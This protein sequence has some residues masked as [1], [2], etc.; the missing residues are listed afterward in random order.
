MLSEL[1]LGW[2][3]GGRKDDIFRSVL[4]R[5]EM[6]DDE[7]NREDTTIRPSCAGLHRRFYDVVSRAIPSLRA[8]V[9]F[10]LQ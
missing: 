7:H 8:P 5:I 10:L 3:G 4:Y 1:L 2:E 9:N 6:N